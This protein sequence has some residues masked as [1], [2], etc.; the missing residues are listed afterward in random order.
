MPWDLAGLWSEWTD[1][2]TGEVVPNFTM[3]TQNCDGHPLLSLM[4]KPDG[5]IPPDKRAGVPIEFC[6]WDVC[7]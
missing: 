2:E 6:V 7:D 3:I 4:H 1:A 5:A